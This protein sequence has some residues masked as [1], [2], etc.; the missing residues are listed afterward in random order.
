VG[1]DCGDSSSVG[2]IS[3]VPI[4]PLDKGGIVAIDC[5]SRG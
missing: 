4:A 5:G 3:G 1:K 2:L